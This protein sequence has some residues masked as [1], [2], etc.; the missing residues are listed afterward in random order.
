M[1]PAALVEARHLVM[2]SVQAQARQVGLWQEHAALGWWQSGLPAMAANLVVHCGPLA[3]DRQVCALAR[4]LAR[5]G[6]AAGWLV[7]PDQRP[8]HQRALL[9]GCGFHLCERIELASF[10]VSQNVSQTVFLPP[11][12]PAGDGAGERVGCRPLAAADRPACAVL[13]QACHG[14]PAAVAAVVAAA[15]VDAPPL[16]LAHGSLQLQ[17]L[18]IWQQG[19]PVATITAALW[20]PLEPTHGPACGGLLW[21]GTD[22]AWRRR[23][24]GMQ[25]TAAACAWLQQQGAQRLHVQASAAAASIYRGLGFAH[26]GWL[27]LWG[28]VPFSRS[29]E[30]HRE[31][32]RPD[33]RRV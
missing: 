16:L 24:Y 20:R 2:A 12:R 32:H 6:P 27:E 21:L 19:R 18:A 1:A 28:C 17:T 33:P 10:N 5:S 14:V 23:G 11:S 15:F 8:E 7:W 4:L 9:Q 30:T 13:L 22:P 29:A 31:R 3:G 26:D 25:V